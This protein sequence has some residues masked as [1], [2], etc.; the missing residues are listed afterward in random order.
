LSALQLYADPQVAEPILAAWP[1]LPAESQAVAVGVLAS[2]REWALA[3]AAAIERGEI[4]PAAV[5]PDVAS[6]LRRYGD[7]V[8]AQLFPPASATL[9]ERE[10]RI[11]ALAELVHQGQ[12]S[13]LAG[14]ALFHGAPACGKC[15]RMFDR[16]GDI[17]PDLTSYNRADLGRLLLA[18]VHPSAEI[19][20]GYEV[21]TVLTADGRLLSGFKVEDTGRLLVLRGADGQTQTIPRDEVDDM[22]PNEASLMPEGLL[23]ALTDDEIRDL[24]AF[25]LST[26]PPM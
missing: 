8:F 2:R 12:G 3:L 11:E 14:Q 21:H 18:L 17:G 9:S 7:S 5:D 25:L 24:F 19:R 23:D 16:G 20:E 26:T 4:P 1:S 15:H 6:R 22:F 13:P 10:A